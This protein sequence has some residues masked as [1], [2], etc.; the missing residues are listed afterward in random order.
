MVHVNFALILMAAQ[1]YRFLDLQVGF[2]YTES[3][4]IRPYPEMD[5]KTFR[6]FS[7]SFNSLMPN[8][9]IS[10]LNKYIHMI[11]SVGFMWLRVIS[12][13]KSFVNTVMNLLVPQNVGNCM[14]S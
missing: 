8:G 13:G 6:W 5:Y 4:T 7:L 11:E 9:M 3:R 2:S 1:E 14:A 12:V 10:K